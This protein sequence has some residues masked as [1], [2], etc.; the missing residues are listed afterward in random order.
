M[1]EAWEKGAK[2][3]TL[4]LINTLDGAQLAAH[5]NMF[6]IRCTLTAFS[7]SDT[8]HWMTAMLAIYW[9]THMGLME[10]AG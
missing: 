7:E 10:L 8:A 4:S 9:M 3:T 5:Y 2:Y 1:K 6:K